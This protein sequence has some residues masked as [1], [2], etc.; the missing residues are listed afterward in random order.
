MSTGSQ[1]EQLRGSL[2]SLDQARSLLHSSGLRD[3]HRGWPTLPGLAQALGLDGLRDLARP[4]GRL[5]PRCPDPD[6]ALNSLERF[7]ATPGGRA[8]LPVLL[9]SRARCLETF[10]QLGSNSQ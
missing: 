10:L 4:L 8:Q 1:L 5:L 3:P 9:E 2:E 6:M 7:L